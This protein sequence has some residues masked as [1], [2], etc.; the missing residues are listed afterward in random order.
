MTR[1]L[2]YLFVGLGLVLLC[3][4]AASVAGQS[5]TEE[6]SAVKDGVQGRLIFS[7]EQ[8][9]NGMRMLAID[10]ELRNVSDVGNPIE[11]YFDPI[12]AFQC[13]VLDAKKHS[14]PQPPL[15]ADILT[16]SPYWI[17]LPYQ[18]SI[19][20]RVSVNGYGIPNDGGRMIQMSCGAWLI[21]LNDRGEYFFKATFAA[22]PPRDSRR[23]AWKGP[24]ELPL[25][26]VPQ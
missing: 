13:D 6:W 21:K 9:F 17:S 2:K 14:V 12:S 5:P 16:P 8:P 25:V 15:V 26:M 20:F 19:R 1:S 18:G 11:I 4:I 22:D 24:L 7:E 10:L 3:G 23:R